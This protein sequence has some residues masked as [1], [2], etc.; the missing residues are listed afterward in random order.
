MPS[1][2]PYDYECHIWTNHTENHIVVCTPKDIYVV[3]SNI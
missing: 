1:D 2:I 3:D